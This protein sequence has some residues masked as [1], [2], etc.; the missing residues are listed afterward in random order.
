M[1]SRTSVFSCLHDRDEAHELVANSLA[2]TIIIIL[3]HH[4]N[5]KI[6]SIRRQYT[7]DS[8]PA[9]LK[10][11]TN[12]MMSIKACKERK[13]LK[14]LGPPVHRAHDTVCHQL[15]IDI[16]ALLSMSTY[17]LRCLELSLCYGMVVF[18]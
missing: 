6:C 13:T 17:Y 3:S 14:D 9:S 10:K 1:Q 4:C 5:D 8:K 12:I 15:L 11:P 18:I 2:C 7:V 16:Y